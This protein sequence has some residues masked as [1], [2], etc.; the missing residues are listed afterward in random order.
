MAGEGGSH[1]NLPGSPFL[2]LT[3]LFSRLEAGL[4]QGRALPWLS[5]QG[6]LQSAGTAAGAGSQQ[7]VLQAPSGHTDHPS[8]EQESLSGRD[9]D[10][11]TETL[12]NPHPKSWPRGLSRSP[13]PLCPA[14]SLPALG[15]ATRA[16]QSLKCLSSASVVTSRTAQ[17]QGP[18]LGATPDSSPPPKGCFLE[19]PLPLLLQGVHFLNPPP[20]LSPAVLPNYHVLPMTARAL[21]QLLP[22]IWGSFLLTGSPAPLPF[23]PVHSLHSALGWGV[24]F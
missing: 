22:G 20:F 3:T 2:A 4:P 7:T 24:F 18:I 19:I 12:L 21:V 6:P 11:Q 16:P 15:L 14:L 5:A 8:D 23:P 13:H 9:M 1:P 17:D 10:M